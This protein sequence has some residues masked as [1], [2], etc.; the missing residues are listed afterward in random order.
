LRVLLIV[1]R[2]TLRRRDGYK[3]RDWL[4]H[5]QLVRRAGRGSAAVSGAVASLVLKG[6]IIAEDAAGKPLHTA[7][8][9][10]SHLG[11]L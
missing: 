8:E 6:L 4:S 5:A 2:Q 1:L 7:E 11:R 10:R 3:A 9:R